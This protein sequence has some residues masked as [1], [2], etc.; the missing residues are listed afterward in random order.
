M[1]AVVIARQ[2]S[3]RRAHEQ[4]EA[5][6]DDRFNVL[7]DRQGESHEQAAWITSPAQ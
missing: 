2:M 1:Q 7:A 6:D 5:G 3:G 4:G